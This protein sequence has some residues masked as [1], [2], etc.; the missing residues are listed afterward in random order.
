MPTLARDLIQET[1]AHLLSGARPEFNYLNGAIADTTTTTV[2]LALAMGGIQRG[3]VLSVDLE[4]MYVF[5]VSAQVATVARGWLGSTA[6]AHAT[7]ALVEVNPRHSDFGILRA[8]NAE[9]V[10]F[11]SPS[12]GLFRVR[13]VDLTYQAAR[14]G[15]DLTSATDLI[16]VLTV[17]AKGSHPG[18]RHRLRSWRLIRDADTADFASGLALY[19][20]DGGAPGR[21]IEVA[22]KAPFVA[23]TALADDVQAVSFLPAAA[24]DIPPLGAAARLVATREVRRGFMDAAPEPRV[25]SD[26]PPGTNRNAATTLLA[27]RNQRLKEESARLHSAYPALTRSA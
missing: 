7:A 5:S 10:S 21:T 8:I 23:L 6:T 1:R 17:E 20:Y 27:L 4:L 13:T 2:T 24:N 19:L 25:A 14:S 9:L 12:N 16:G 22:Y 26:V 15:Y 18:D 3:A 11:S